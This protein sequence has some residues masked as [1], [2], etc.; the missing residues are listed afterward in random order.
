[1]GQI[2]RSLDLCNALVGDALSTAGLNQTDGSNAQRIYAVTVS[3]DPTDPTT[4]IWG[5]QV[6]VWPSTQDTD[7]ETRGTLS[8]ELEVG[9]TIIEMC[10]ATPAVFSDGDLVTPGTIVQSDP[11]VS[12]VDARVTWCESYFDSIKTINKIIGARATYFRRPSVEPARITLTYDRDELLE[13]K[14]FWCD[15]SIT[16][17]GWT[18]LTGN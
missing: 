16:F 18:D 14:L 3:V 11:P 15:M 5:R 10:L 7:Q 12:W 17:R 1:M 4:F 2:A 13:R 8:G 6:Y 9:I